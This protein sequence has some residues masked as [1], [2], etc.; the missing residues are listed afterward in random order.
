[1]SVIETGSKAAELGLS[2][3]KLVVMT[4]DIEGKPEL[5]GPAPGVILIPMSEFGFDGPEP[6]AMLFFAR[7]FMEIR[8]HLPAQRLIVAAGGQICLFWPESSAIDPHT[9]LDFAANLGLTEDGRIHL[10]RGWTG[11]KLAA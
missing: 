8:K 9:I 5:L 4:G 6:D 2:P 10:D 11:L 3:G 7:D 1:M